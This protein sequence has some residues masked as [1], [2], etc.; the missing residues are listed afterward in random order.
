VDGSANIATLHSDGISVAARRVDL[1][2]LIEGGPRSQIRVDLKARGGG[3][4]LDS[5]DGQLALNVPEG[6]FDGSRLG[7]IR[8]EAS[9]SKGHFALTE[10]LAV[11]P[12][13][14]FTAAGGGTLAS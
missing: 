14:R 7:P 4:S 12:G 13:A 9:A 3:D 10:L 11:L 6:E 8:A 5:A 1:S 2:E